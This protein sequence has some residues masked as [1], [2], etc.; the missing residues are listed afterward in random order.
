M[1]H[2]PGFQGLKALW[3]VVSV[4]CT[5]YVVCC[6]SCCCAQAAACQCALLQAFVQREAPQH[7]YQG[8]IWQL[9]QLPGPAAR[10]PA[11]MLLKGCS[12][13]V[14]AEG[15]QCSIAWRISAGHKHRQRV[16]SSVP[17]IKASTTV[18]PPL[19]ERSPEQQPYNVLHLQTVKCLVWGAVVTVELY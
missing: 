18:V 15:R 10:A 19:H 8:I 14:E 5:V 2:Q 11:A 16:H 17:L 7:V 1:P 4:Q 6:C 13:G 9:Q 12:R 3:R